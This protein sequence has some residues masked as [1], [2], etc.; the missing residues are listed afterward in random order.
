MVKIGDRIAGGAASAGCGL[1]TVLPIL[2]LVWGEFAGVYH[3]ARSHGMGDAA[4]AFFVPP[5][6]WYRSIEYFW[7]DDGR[8]AL[9]SNSAKLFRSIELFN[10]AN[11]LAR[12][13]AD[14]RSGSVAYRDEA[15]RKLESAEAVA[16]EVDIQW[17]E[18][19]M[20]GLGHSFRDDYIW[21]L[22]RIRNAGPDFDADA[23]TRR[24]GQFD[25]KLKSCLAIQRLGLAR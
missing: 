10:E 5:Y 3:A 6:A 22:R 12:N 19:Q 20:T 14:A 23:V 25:V 15:M 18:R 16:L 4:I 8:Q 13:A 9:D 7:H 17:L 1:V 24:M 2:A 21:G 11:A